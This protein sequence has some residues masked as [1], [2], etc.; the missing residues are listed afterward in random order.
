MDSARV[1]AHPQLATNGSRSGQRTAQGRIQP[2]FLGGGQ[3]VGTN[4]TN[5]ATSSVTWQF[6]RLGGGGHG[7]VGPPGSALDAAAGEGSRVLVKAM[8]FSG[9]ANTTLKKTIISGTPRENIL[10]AFVNREPVNSGHRVDIC[11]I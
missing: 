4:Q 6:D 3:P 10:G 8:S 9:K 5:Q 1:P 11:Q 2:A 7:P